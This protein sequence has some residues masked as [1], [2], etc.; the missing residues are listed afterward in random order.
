M[1]IYSQADKLARSFAK[2]NK[3]YENFYFIKQRLYF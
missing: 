2:Y 3:P 1:L